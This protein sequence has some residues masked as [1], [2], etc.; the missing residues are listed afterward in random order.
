MRVGVLMAVWATLSVWVRNF[1]EFESAKAYGNAHTPKNLLE[2]QGNR[3]ERQ[4][5]VYT[6]CTRSFRQYRHGQLTHLAR[7]RRHVTE[8][9]AM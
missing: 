3:V 7:Y 5:Q 2:C 1:K 6:R 8:A 4:H 9:Q